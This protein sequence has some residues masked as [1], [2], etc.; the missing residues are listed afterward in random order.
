MQT[1]KGFLPG[2]QVLFSSTSGNYCRCLSWVK[3]CTKWEHQ[4]VWVNDLRW[5]CWEVS[6]APGCGH[7]DFGQTRVRWGKGIVS[8]VLLWP[9]SH[10][11]ALTWP[12]CCDINVSTTLTVRWGFDGWI[13]VHEKKQQ[14]G[15]RWQHFTALHTSLFLTH[16]DWT[17]QSEAGWLIGLTNLWLTNPISRLPLWLEF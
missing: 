3:D 7:N 5:L 4:S 16:Y 2:F 11:E 12:W 8:A 15:D 1:V 13:R 9:Y 17:H 14:D 6:A 10:H